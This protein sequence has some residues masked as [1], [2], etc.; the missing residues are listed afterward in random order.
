MWAWLRE[1]AHR[2]A[3][4]PRRWQGVFAAVLVWLVWMICGFWSTLLLVVL[5]TAG[6]AVGRV[7]EERYDWKT[8]L[9]KLFSDRYRDS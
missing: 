8:V 7:L 5:G 9:E 1:T 3:R 4:L 2:I 6:Y